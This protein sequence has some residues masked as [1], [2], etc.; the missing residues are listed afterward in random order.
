[1]RVLDDETLALPSYDGNGM[2]LSAGNATSNAKV[3]L[4]FIDFVRPHRLRIHGSARL[5]RSEAE[6]A[7][8]PGAELLLVVK[9]YEAFVN[10]PRY[11]HR[12]GRAGISPFVPGEPRGEEAAPWKNIDI[13]RDSI[14]ARDRRRLEKAGTAPVTVEE[15][16]AR[17][18]RGET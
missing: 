4:L 3:G 12:Y 18:Q 14:P 1:V 11:I 16:S 13:I 10:C 7:A 2:Y 17:R 9:V 8:Y 6:L 15:Y 5:V